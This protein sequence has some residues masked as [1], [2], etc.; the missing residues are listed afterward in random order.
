MGSRLCLVTRMPVFS[1]LRRVLNV[2]NI[3]K[4]QVRN[5]GYSVP[6]RPSRWVYDKFKDDVHFYL[7]IMG[8]PLGA[9]ITLTNLLYSNAQLS[10]IPRVTLPRS[11]NITPTPSPGS[12]LA[13]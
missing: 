7:A 8:I 1:S 2:K 13:T 12:L 6:I 4:S 3:V 11:G 10:A 9:A 5:S